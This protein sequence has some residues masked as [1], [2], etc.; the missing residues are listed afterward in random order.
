MT[1]I[2]HAPSSVTT[3]PSESRPNRSRALLLAALAV[4]AIVIVAIT[5]W[6]WLPSSSHSTSTTQSRHVTQVNPGRNYRCDP[7]PN[8]S[9]C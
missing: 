2:Q 1:A 7:L 4:A 6:V 3:D 8:A 5:L 9:L